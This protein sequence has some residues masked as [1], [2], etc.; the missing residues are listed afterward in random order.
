MLRKEL[1]ASEAR[2][3]REL[4]E[5]RALLVDELE[6]KNAALAAASAAKSNFLA[7]MSHEIRTPMNAVIG[8]TELALR[9]NLN[10][11]QHDYL[12]KIKASARSLLGVIN[13]ILDF[14]KIEAGKLDLEHAPFELR[15]VL[16]NL[17]TVSALAAA[18][19]GLELIFSIDPMV[20]AVLVGDPLRIGQILYNLVGNANK[21]TERGEIIVSV[22]IAERD[23]TSVVLRCAVA[24]TGIGMSETTRSALFEPFT[25]ADSSTTRRF[26][27]TGLGLAICRQLVG[28]MGGAISVES[29]LG[30]GSTFTFTLRNGIGA[31][32]RD[33][34]RPSL[35]SITSKRILVVDDVPHV[36]EILGTTLR[37]WSIFVEETVSGSAAV[38]AIRR[39]I[40]EDRP[41]DLVLLDWR[42]PGLDGV[43]TARLVKEQFGKDVP[44]IV[45][46]TAHGKEDLI[47][48]CEDIGIASVL[49]KPITN[50]SLLDAISSALGQEVVHR[51]KS[52]DAPGHVRPE[53]AGKRVL[54]VDDNDI[55]RQVGEELLADAGVIVD[56]AENGYQAVA[57]VLDSAIP[58]DAV[59]MDV[60][61]PEMDG[62]EATRIIRRQFGPDRLPII[63]LTAH[64]LEEERQHSLD[65]GM[66]DHLAKPIDST[67]LISTLARWVNPPPAASAEPVKHRSAVTGGNVTASAHS[68]QPVDDLPDALPP[69]DLSAALKRVSGKRHL[70]KRLLLSFHDEFRDSTANLKSMIESGRTTDAIRLAHTLKSAAATL[71]ATAVAHIARKIEER[72]SRAEGEP[73][74]LL[75]SVLEGKLT[76]AIDAAASLRRE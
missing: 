33:T 32:M 42:M 36:R 64:A 68:P 2:A 49:A 48:R 57:K 38:E 34:D 53:V 58:Y 56:L 29:A 22:A 74:E 67:S 6:S 28:M 19:K 27:G 3:A 4:A 25:Q 60:Q 37:H 46:M 13:D 18:E 9:T 75:I 8:L 44:K 21:F 39:A 51:R 73:V 35:S 40:A 1:E 71:E 76:P 63:A 14:S 30:R 65:A 41:Y 62:L 47:R 15:T 5:I 7:N 54:L 23:E 24:D 43:E 72:L 11:K 26:G 50:S 66:N 59:F 10:P 16:D 69:F 55:N 45:M 17:A 12:K 70:L 61:M 20:P 31:E 52:R